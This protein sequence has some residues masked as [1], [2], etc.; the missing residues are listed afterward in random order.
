M[1]L[2]TLVKHNLKLDVYAMDSDRL[3]AVR[4]GENRQAPLPSWFRRG[5]CLGIGGGHRSIHRWPTCAS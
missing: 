4:G 1:Y 5:R 2:M 3:P